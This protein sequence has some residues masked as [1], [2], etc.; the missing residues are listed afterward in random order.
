MTL[1]TGFFDGVHL[2]HRA[3]LDGAQLALT[4]LNHPLEVLNPIEAP[5]LITDLETRLKLINLPTTV[6][7]FD[8]QLAQM[9]AAQFAERFLKGY[10]IRCGEN[11]RFG[12]GAE[13]SPE[14]LRNNGY[15]VEVVPYVEYQGA[16]ISSS[17][18]RSA[19]ENGALNLAEA[20]L[21]RTFS[22]KGTIVDGKGKGR[23]LGFPTLNLD[24]DEMPPLKRGVYSALVNYGLAPTFGAAA[25]N[26]PVMEAHLM[27]FI[28]EERRFDSIE[29]LKAQIK[30][31]LIEGAL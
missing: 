3:I 25:W 26:T 6:L 4:F 7:K 14:W 18:I 22:V 30:Q 27:K 15:E 9:S 28:R 19:L 17:R 31:D 8:E 29:E 2:G 12:K 21:G 23:S 24:R 11:W 1:A 5:K 20:M 10:R 16:A 13:G